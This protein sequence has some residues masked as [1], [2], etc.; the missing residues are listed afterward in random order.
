MFSVVGWKKSFNQSAKLAE[1][2]QPQARAAEPGDRTQ[3]TSQPTEWATDEAC[4]KTSLDSE[5]VICRLTTCVAS[6]AGSQK[7][8][9]CYPRLGFAI[10]WGYQSAR[11]LRRLVEQFPLSSLLPFSVCSANCLRFSNWRL[12]IIKSPQGNT[13]CIIL[14]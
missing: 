7:L 11:P 10:A 3:N 13:V 14:P 2:L 6:F 4:T 8:A 12:I 5:F 1:R 9:A